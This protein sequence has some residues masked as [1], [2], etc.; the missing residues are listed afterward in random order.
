MPKKGFGFKPFAIT[1]FNQGAVLPVAL[2]QKTSQV[3]NAQL[4]NEPL[5]G[6]GV[7]SGMPI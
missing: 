2:I 7:K 5:Q 1:A 6:E 3:S 4:S